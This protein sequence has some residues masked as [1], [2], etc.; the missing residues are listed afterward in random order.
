MEM[1]K[2]LLHDSEKEDWFG[3]F[4]WLG[5][6]CVCG[7]MPI[8]ITV[9][10][11]LLFSQELKVTL[12]T[13]NGE[14]ALYSASFVGSSLY[15]VMQDWKNKSFPSMGAF[16]LLLISILACSAV[17]YA[18]VAL[19]GVLN[20]SDAFLP[21]LYNLFDKDF[22]RKLSFLI[23]PITFTLSFIVVVADKIRLKPNIK[24]GLEKLED[25]FES[26]EE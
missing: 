21:D 19:V 1:I 7:L 25:D 26:L 2:A 13:N 22:L 11:L 15:L 24:R 12:F 23:L 6:S 10:I 3:G 17:M 20:G 14:F 9:L 18:L 5:F 8:W 4:S 16:S